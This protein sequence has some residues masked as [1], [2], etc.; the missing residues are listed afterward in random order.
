M[1]F[2]TWIEIKYPD[3]QSRRDYM[4][5]HLIPDVDLG[6]GNF[7][8]FIAEREGLMLSEYSKLLKV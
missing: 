2:K 6:L 8:V 5:K 4:R 3:E 7:D 1:D